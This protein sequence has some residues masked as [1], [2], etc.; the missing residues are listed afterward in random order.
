[1]RHLGCAV[2]AF[3]ALALVAD[4]RLAA[5]RSVTARAS[6]WPLVDRQ[7]SH[8]RR[9]ALAAS[10]S[11]TPRGATPEQNWRLWP[12]LPIFP[13]GTRKTIRS[14]VVPGKVW[15]FDQLQGI[16]Y[17]HVP[18]RM[19]VVKI[20]D[21]NT[22]ED[23]LLMYNA[24][25]PTK[26]CLALVRELEEVHG[27]VMHVVLPTLGVEH[28]VFAGPFARNFKGCTLWVLPDQYSFPVDLPLS[29]VGFAGC[30]VRK[31]PPTSEGTPW[32]EDMDHTILGTFR[33]RDG[34]FGEAAFL[35]RPSSSLL[36][37]DTI[38]CASSRLPAIM[39]TDLPALLFHARN[40]GFESVSDSPDTR[41][42]GWERIVLFALY[43]NPG[44]TPAPG[45]WV[46]PPLP[47]FFT[48]VVPHTATGIRVKSL[49]E[50]FSD[51]AAT[52]PDM[53]KLGWFSLYPWD[54][55]PASARKSF[56]AIADRPLV[57]PVLRE[58]ILDR[59]PEETLAF[60]KRVARWRFSQIV[61]AHLNS[62]VKAGPS[63]FLR[64]FYFLEKKTIDLETLLPSPLRRAEP[65]ESDLKLL[66]EVSQT[67]VESGVTPPPKEKVP[68]FL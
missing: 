58:L 10:A 57:P 11:V 53:K 1:M 61:P 47:P 7:R 52:P 25:A 34:A 21:A 29:W 32:A 26:E 4:A 64:A 23:G 33:S 24:V 68:S 48:P 15:T 20:R 54:W 59:N 22:G 3:G 30:R 63:D 49:Q 46:A 16:I 13:Y 40:T 19:T 37:T 42:Q 36:V 43:F 51:N 60:A 27:R 6:V 62:P 9:C 41:R 67:L 31:L 5:P 28:K 45:W 39:E 38:V 14:T 50:A 65:P 66:R 12:A 8:S 17:V 55:D 35:H 56:A 2:V 18:V 44:G